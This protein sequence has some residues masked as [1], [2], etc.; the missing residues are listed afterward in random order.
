MKSAVKSPKKHCLRSAPEC[1]SI[2]MMINMH[3]CRNPVQE[4]NE[5]GTQE[6]RCVDGEH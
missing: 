4:G 1:D 2:V 6:N 3:I 5:D